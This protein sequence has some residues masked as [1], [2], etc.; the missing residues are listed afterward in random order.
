MSFLIPAIAGGASLLSSLFGSRAQ[1]NAA[2]Q[3]AKLY[4][5][6]LRQYQQTGQGLW[7]QATGA[8]W[9][10]FGPKTSTSQGTTTGTSSTQG[11][12]T[13]SNRPEITAEYAPLDALMRGIM[14]Q[15]LA[16]G[17]GLPQGYESTA[18]RA[19]NESYAGAD[20]AA[21]NLAA[22]RGLSGEQTYAVASPAAAARAGALADMRSQLPLLARQ[23]QNEDIAAT[24]GLQAAFGRGEAGKER[25]WQTGQTTGQQFGTSTTPF[26]AGDLSALMN[27]LMPPGPQQSGLT[28]QSTVGAG[29]DSL[30]ALLGFLASQQGAR[31]TG[32][33]G[34]YGA[35]GAPPTPWGYG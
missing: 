34:G 21:R 12:R 25:S 24:Q 23:L 26:T 30:G 4:N 27:V 3:Q 2:E 9:N 13:Y 28:G 15:R 31:S 19:I 22:R 17:T 33:G 18:A 6:W 14:T 20:Q 11:G 29:L 32:G 10:P 35:A 1:S 8:G 16:S 7:G 5:D